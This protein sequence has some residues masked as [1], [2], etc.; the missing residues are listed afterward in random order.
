MTVRR[1]SNQVVGGSNPSGRT[2]YQ[3]KFFGSPG[4]EI[5]NEQIEPLTDN[6]T[7]RLPGAAPGWTSPLLR[8]RSGAKRRTSGAAASHPSGRTIQ[9][10]SKP[11]ISRLDRQLGGGPYIAMRHLSNVRAAPQVTTLKALLLPTP[12]VYAIPRIHN[13]WRATDRLVA[14]PK[15]EDQLGRHWWRSPRGSS[16]AIS[17][18]TWPIAA[19]AR[20]HNLTVATGNVMDF[21]RPGVKVFNPFA[22]SESQ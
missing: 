11:P 4:H 17:R 20:R 9:I 12:G 18:L 22:E 8:R 6:K 5:G 16:D 19:I 13:L 7:V 2:F 3:K 14:V 1:A 10:W 21:Q 15:R